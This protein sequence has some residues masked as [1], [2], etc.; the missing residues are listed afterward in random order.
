MYDQCPKLIVLSFS[1]SPFN[2]PDSS[3]YVPLVFQS[4]YP[5]KHQVRHDEKVEINGELFYRKCSS[6]GTSGILVNPRHLMV[7][8][9]KEQ[10]RLEKEHNIPFRRPSGLCDQS[11]HSSV[12]VALLKYAD[13]MKEEYKSVIQVHTMSN[14]KKARELIVTNLRDRIVGQNHNKRNV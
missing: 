3:F 11:L 10:L 12:K 7:Q 2:L 14:I 9:Q 6:N 8:L 13:T 4:N 1:N 5:S